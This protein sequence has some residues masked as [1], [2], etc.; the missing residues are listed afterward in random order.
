MSNAIW[1]SDVSASNRLDRTVRRLFMK[2]ARITETERIDEQ[3]RLIT[4]ASPAFKGVSWRPGQKVQIAMKAMFTA[5]TYTPIEWDAVAGTTCILG[6]AHGTAP[7]SEWLRHVG[8]G[9]ECSLGGPR[10]AL[11]VGGDAAP[12]VVI[13]D[14]TTIGL[15]RALRMP[16]QARPVSCLF[17]VSEPDSARRA[18]SR[19]GLDHA[20]LIRRTADESHLEALEARAQGLITPGTRFALTGK[21]S[22]IKRLQRALKRSGVLPSRLD[23]KVHWSPGRTGLD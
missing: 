17:E 8:P 19:L 9:D 15:A 3:F 22:S 12:L 23:A 14:E 7:G 16:E 1:T 13:G 6:H 21:A 4:L 18:A 10:R 11:D 2:P 5:R 20:V